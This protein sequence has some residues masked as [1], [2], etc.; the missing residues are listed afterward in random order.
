MARS[1]LSGIDRAVSTPAGQDTA[2]LGP[3]DSSDSG[4]D[5]AGAE[6]LEGGDPSAPIDVATSPDTGH[7]GPA[8][9]ML[10]PGF[11]TDAAG[12]GERRSAG[13]DAGVLDA[14]DI[15]PDHVVSITEISASSEEAET[16]LAEESEPAD[17]RIA[18]AV[19]AEPGEA[20]EDDTEQ[21]T[22][23][24]P[25]SRRAPRTSKT[26][27]KRVRGERSQHSRPKGR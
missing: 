3:S 2:S 25:V 10:G 27:S 13:G 11:D 5:I 18:A 1:S 12:T 14:P 16:P 17:V 4:S 6:D 20:E 21:A 15:A 8:A 7:P 22:Q 24:A 23:P 26:G 19:M 9:E